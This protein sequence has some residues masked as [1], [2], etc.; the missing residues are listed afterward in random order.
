MFDFQIPQVSPVTSGASGPKMDWRPFFYALPVAG[1]LIA[2][3]TVEAVSS[4]ALRASV[5]GMDGV[6]SVMAGWLGRHE[7]DAGADVF[8]GI[9]IIASAIGATYVI[10]KQV[11]ASMDARKA[12]E[13][14]Q[15]EKR[16]KHEMH[17]QARGASIEALM[18]ASKDFSHY[19]FG[20]V[21]QVT[22]EVSTR[23]WQVR[24]SSLNQL[25]EKYNG[26]IEYSKWDLS[27]TDS[28]LWDRIDF[29][30]VPTYAARGATAAKHIA[31]LAEAV[32]ARVMP[33]FDV[34]D[35]SD[36]EV[37]VVRSSVKEMGKLAKQIDELSSIC[38][39]WDRYSR[40]LPPMVPPVH[41]KKETPEQKAE[42]EEIA[43]ERAE[44]AREMAPNFIAA[45]GSYNYT[46]R[47]MRPQMQWFVDSV[48]G[49]RGGFKRL[50]PGLAENKSYHKDFW[51]TWNSDLIATEPALRTAA[52]YLDTHL[53]RAHEWHLGE[54]GRLLE[55]V[56][57]HGERLLSRLAGATR[58]I[59]DEDGADK[60][61]SVYNGFVRKY[62]PPSAVNDATN[63]YPQP[64]SS[65]CEK[66]QENGQKRIADQDQKK[67]YYAFK[68]AQRKL[69]EKSQEKL[70]VAWMDP[71][72]G[73]DPMDE[74]S[75]EPPLGS[76]IPTSRPVDSEKRKKMREDSKERSKQAR[77]RQAKQLA[78][79]AK[80][81]R[82][83]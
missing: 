28:E 49:D 81:P 83:K 3:H 57:E 59:I 45:I 14:E 42:R 30:E 35:L 25:M 76:P 13:T 23:H 65:Y 26:V 79:E 8:A 22:E 11:K 16:A 70:S 40:A 69:V 55:I 67:R 66:S 4:I 58:A 52:Q 74:M 7:I 48:E 6:I 12:W 31:R 61:A 44:A 54:L 41:P 24:K 20:E 19:F 39:V 71:Y 38:R 18:G 72:E 2:A 34:L 53:I 21:R 32:E 17:A 60:H 36:H 5:W 63:I 15:A 80:G 75:Q 43:E 77:I 9:S 68:E 62:Y 50:K 64:I 56:S 33:F 29:A 10:G 82:R 1:V 73:F 27:F 78:D 47:Y 37:A 51:E 46:N